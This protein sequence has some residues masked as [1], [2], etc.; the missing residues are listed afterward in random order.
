MKEDNFNKLKEDVYK[1]TADEILKIINKKRIDYCYKYDTNPKYI[2][3]PTAIKYL[4]ENELNVYFLMNNI[5]RDKTLEFI[6]GLNV[7]DTL[8]ITQ[9]DEIEVF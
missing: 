9:I 3:I 7:C 4:L 5:Q 6:Y 2:K 8:S 1:S